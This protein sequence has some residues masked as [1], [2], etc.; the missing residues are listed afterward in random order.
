MLDSVELALT[1]WARWGGPDADLDWATMYI[2]R[3]RTHVF[4]WCEEIGV[5]WTDLG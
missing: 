5:V 3:S 2:E 4:D 1:D